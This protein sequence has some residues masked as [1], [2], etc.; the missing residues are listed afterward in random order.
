MLCVVYINCLLL[1]DTND[2]NATVF[3]VVFPGGETSI[4]DVD[5]FISINDDEIDEADDQFF[6]VYLE[7]VNATNRLAQLER[8]ISICNIVDNDREFDY[9]IY[10]CVLISLSC[11]N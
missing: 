8:V 5:A 4:A 9:S 6:V 2:F 11:S 10:G 1:I 7:I 3:E